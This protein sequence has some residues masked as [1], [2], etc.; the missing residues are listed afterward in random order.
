[1]ES[2][3]IHGKDYFPVNERL[4]VFRK[5]YKGFS[6]ESTITHMAG[7]MCVVKAVIKNESERIV[8]TGHAYEREGRGNINKTSYVENCETSAWGRALGNLGIGIDENVASADEVANAL[9]NKDLKLE[10]E[11]KPP[12]DSTDVID[13]DQLKLLCTT[14]KNNDRDMDKFKQWLIDTYQID[15]KK[16]I[17]KMLFDEIMDV[18]RGV[19]K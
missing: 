18:V 14:L 11:K 1:M 10:G 2:I 12:V 13:A 9:M 15:S 17:P 6:L 4:K 7:D 5:D 19:S 3:K 8:A 16:K